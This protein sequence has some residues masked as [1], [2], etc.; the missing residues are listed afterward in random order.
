M[1]STLVKATFVMGSEE[2]SPESISERIGIN[3]NLSGKKGE[4][5]NGKMPYPDSFWEVFTKREASLDVSDQIK[6]IIKILKPSFQKLKDLIEEY[7]LTPL[8]SVLIVID[9]GEAPSLS[10]SREE[11][12]FFNNLNTEMDFDIYANP[13]NDSN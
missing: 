5:V 10:L 1:K 4:I 8:L 7:Q 6:K 13:Y 9:N 11:I 3:P 12:S 2:I